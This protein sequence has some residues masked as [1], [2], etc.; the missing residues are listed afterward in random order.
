MQRMPNNHCGF[1]L[2]ELTIVIAI[3]GVLTAIA[4][5]KFLNITANTQKIATTTIAR[6]LS[7][8]NLNN[9]GARKINPSFGTSV[10][11][12]TDIASTMQGGLPSGYAIIA[13]PVTIDATV[14]CFLSGAEC[15][16]C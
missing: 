15:N 10:T 6:A 11:N 2:I 8:T 14:N 16:D 12:C 4:V 7:S 13:A 3:I 5:P 9:Y 1:T